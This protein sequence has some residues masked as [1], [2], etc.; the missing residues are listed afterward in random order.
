M[1]SGKIENTV[2]EISNIG[3]NKTLPFNIRN[4]IFDN[5][6][7]AFD[8]L[9]KAVI[10]AQE[11]HQPL[12]MAKKHDDEP[13]MTIEIKADIAERQRLWFAGTE[14]LESFMQKN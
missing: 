14:R 10:D 6:Q 7:L 2:N 1:R 11:K 12:K 4:F 3:Q 5:K 13:W 8:S 9:Y